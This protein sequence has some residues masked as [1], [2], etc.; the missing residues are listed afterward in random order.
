MLGRKVEILTEQ[1]Q[2][3][4]LSDREYWDMRFEIEAPDYHRMKTTLCKPLGLLA[5]YL[6]PFYMTLA[7]K[8]F[9]AGKDLAVI[10]KQAEVNKHKHIE[11]ETLFDR[12]QAQIKLLKG[13]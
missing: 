6:T 9:M 10:K 12:K 13:L 1:H 4:L 3:G 11:R 7:Y 8:R 2:S 5:H